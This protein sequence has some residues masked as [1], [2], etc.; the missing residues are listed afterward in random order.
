VL[1][2]LG[3]VSQISEIDLNE[4]AVNISGNWDQMLRPEGRLGLEDSW[5]KD[6]KVTT[7]A[8]FRALKTKTM[9]FVLIKWEV[10]G[11]FKPQSNILKKKKIDSG[12]WEQWLTPAITAPQEEEFRRVRF[13]GQPRQNS[14]QHPH[15]NRRTP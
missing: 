3:K 1:H 10:H 14:Q 4:K 7:Q 15:L 2:Y 9:D 6:S 13:P 12:G 5:K 8:A 11:G